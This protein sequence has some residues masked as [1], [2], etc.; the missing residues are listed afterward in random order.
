[1]KLTALLTGALL[2]ATVAFSAPAVA[3]SADQ[4]DTGTAQAASRVAEP[5][6]PTRKQG[7]KQAKAALDR[8]QPR[9]DRYVTRNG[10]PPSLKVAV[11]LVKRSNTN[12]VI[13]FNYG[14]HDGE[15]CLSAYH[16]T[17]IGQEQFF[18]DSITRKKTY[19]T[20]G[21]VYLGACVKILRA[22]ARAYRLRSDLTHFIAG[23][24]AYRAETGTLP[25]NLE[26]EWQVAYMERQPRQVTRV[27]EYIVDGETY[28]F[29]LVN[30]KGAWATYDATTGA[31]RKNGYNLACRY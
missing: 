20:P 3:T 9:I 31:M 1:M 25:E 17:V 8:A 24:D 2:A 27:G 14:Q 28:R 4:P 30:R 29:C 11:R 15:Y 23:I 13:G 10:R 22:S 19:N 5:E 6:E 12:P 21:E 16:E 18:Y 7:R 26:E